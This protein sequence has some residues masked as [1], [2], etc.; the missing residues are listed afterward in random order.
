[1]T[2]ADEFQRACLDAIREGR[3]LTP[4]YVPTAWI[5]MIDRHGAVEAAK[6]LLIS[7]DTQ[8][9]F[10]RLVQGGRED[11]TVEHAVLQPRWRSLFGDEHRAAAEWRLG[12]AR[13]PAGR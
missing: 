4:P 13:S 8:S 7:G 9:G 11:L 10:F 12:R 2:L 5:D 3:S 1:M 6:R